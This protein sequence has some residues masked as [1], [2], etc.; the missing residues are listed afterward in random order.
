MTYLNGGIF[1]S[2]PMKM[3]PQAYII[4]DQ[5]WM[6]APMV[7]HIATRLI[8]REGRSNTLLR[9]NFRRGWPFYLAALF[10]PALATI[11]GATIYYL[12]FPSRFDLSMTYARD[13]LGLVPTVGDY[14]S[15]DVPHHPD[16]PHHRVIHTYPAIDVWRG[17]R[18]AGVPAAEADAARRAQGRAACRRD[19]WRVALAD[20]S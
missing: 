15:V 1:I 2:Y 7:A 16:A 18:L 19:P 9:P 14:G 20:S 5:C 13:M 8:T 3:R 12:L 4:D 10:L 11:V 6:F 17:V